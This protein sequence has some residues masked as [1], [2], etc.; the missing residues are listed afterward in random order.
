[1][2]EHS[3]SKILTTHTD[4]ELQHGKSGILPCFSSHTTLPFLQSRLNQFIC[5]LRTSPSSWYTFSSALSK[6]R[7]YGTEGSNHF[8]QILYQEYKLS[9]LYTIQV[10]YAKYSI[11]PL[12]IR[13]IY[14]TWEQ[15]KLT[16]HKLINGKKLGEKKFRK[17]WAIYG[18][19]EGILHT[20]KQQGD[21][22]LRRHTGVNLI[23]KGDGKP[24]P[25]C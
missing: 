23:P 6:G 16:I 20:C 3:V 10:L 25:G 22:T 14:Q 2:S 7:L 8:R 12:Y 17:D 19:T 4:P 24:S 18:G 15:I 9:P 11:Y 21:F 5:T 1:M 13:Y